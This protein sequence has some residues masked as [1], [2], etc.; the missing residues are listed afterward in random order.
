MTAKTEEILESLKII[1]PPQPP[2]PG[3]PLQAPS[4]AASIAIFCILFIILKP[5]LDMSARKIFTLF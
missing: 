2:G 4:V 3:F 1:K 5:I